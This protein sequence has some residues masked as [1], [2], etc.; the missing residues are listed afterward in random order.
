MKKVI[1]Q[2]YDSAVDYVNSLFEVHSKLQVLRLDLSY[3][4]EVAN[5]LTID[6]AKKDIQHLLNNRRSKP[7]LFS[8]CVGHI[9]KLETTE[10]KGPH[11]HTAFFYDGS[12]ILHDAHWAGKIA[13]Y[14]KDRITNGRGIAF[15]CNAKK[16]EYQ[17]VGI[18]QISHSDGEKR[19]NLVT[20]VL[21]YLTKT[22]QGIDAAKSGNDR[23]FGRGI[24]PKRTTKKGRP[25]Q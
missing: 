9:W 6:D 10:E 14:W 2:N 3:R 16:G 5:T 8:D 23:C 13:D 4:K 22:D 24:A 15:N 17:K 18:G 21:P 12:K 7:S 1:Q 19:S 11:F 20:E 25:R